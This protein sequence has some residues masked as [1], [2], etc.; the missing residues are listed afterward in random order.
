M[1]KNNWLIYGANGFTGELISR[2]AHARGLS[3]I[4]AGRTCEPVM[5][6]AAELNLPFR[7]FSLSSQEDILTQISDCTLVLNCAGPFAETA[8]PMARAAIHSGAHYLDI[9]GEVWVYEK[10]QALSAAAEMARV[11]LLPGVGFDVVPTDCV[12]NLLKQKLPD[13]TQ[14]SLAFVGANQ[15]A[16]GSIKTAL[17]QMPS[18]SL[19]REGG[20]L[21]AIPFFSRSRLLQIAG[22]SHEVHAIPWGDLSTAFH[23]TGIADITVFTAFPGLQAHVLRMAQPFMGILRNRAVLRY[24]ESLTDALA[25]QPTAASLES[26]RTYI[27][28]KVSNSMGSTAE[29]TLR[30][31]DTYTV[32]RDASL[33]IISEILGGKSKPG[34]HTCSQV[35]GAD[36]IYRLPDVETISD[37]VT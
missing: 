30:I 26:A 11:M 29:I 33:L 13:A 3:P 22:Q 16:A 24:V 5:R 20:K 27:W 18:G 2:E 14:L 28:G 6:L 25:P 36:F 17:R 31:R 34:F 9:S 32:T 12:A 35:F 23:S 21:K 10:L 19:V 1:K 8:E 15:A 4:L 37:S 7:C